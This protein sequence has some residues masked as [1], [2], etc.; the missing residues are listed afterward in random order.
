MSMS[1]GTIFV[2]RQPDG[3]WLHRVKTTTRTINVIGGEKWRESTRTA[4]W[5]SDAAEA[6][7]FQVRR[8]AESVAREIREGKSRG[9][10]QPGRGGMPC[11]VIE[12][13][14]TGPADP[15]QGGLW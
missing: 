10:G 9:V 7:R 4:V 15:G 2:I 13:A 8:V 12:I 6:R 5:T 11:K 14:P 1:A 3:S